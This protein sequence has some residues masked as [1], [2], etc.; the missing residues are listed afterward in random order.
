MNEVKHNNVKYP[1]TNQFRN[2]IQHITKAE[3]FC[4]RYIAQKVKDFVIKSLS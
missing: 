4:G 1:S 3:R 2:V